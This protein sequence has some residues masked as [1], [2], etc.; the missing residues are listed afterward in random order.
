MGESSC[1]PGL[2]G[3]GD[4][5]GLNFCCWWRLEW[6]LLKAT[7]Q[8]VWAKVLGTSDS[9]RCSGQESQ[10]ALFAC[11]IR[12]LL[13]LWP[14]QSMPLVF[15]VITRMALSGCSGFS[16]LC[17]SATLAADSK[18]SN[19][20]SVRKSHTVHTIRNFPTRSVRSL[21]YFSRL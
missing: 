2:G 3:R 21:I 9:T 15:R 7:C 4:L 11:A 18:S 20:Y 13:R 6:R 10:S 19:S 1:L 16:A 5:P 14:W 17:A 8:E 12:L